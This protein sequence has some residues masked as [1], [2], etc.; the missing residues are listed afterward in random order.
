MKAFSS[1]LLLLVVGGLT[2]LALTFT[3]K[4]LPVPELAD[5]ELPKATPPLGMTLS[6]LPTGV[7]QSQAAFAYRGGKFGDAREFSMAGILVHHP[8]G[9]LLFDTG[10]G[11]SVDEDFRTQP[12]LMQWT[13]KYSKGTPIV[14]QF[15]AN[16]YDPKQL[17]G[18]VLTHAH[19]DH[20]S[21]LR[22]LAG[23]PVWVDQA[24]RDFIAGDAPAAALVRGMKDQQY[25]LYSFDNG[26]YL[27]YERSLDVWGDG[28]VVLVPAPGHTPG[29][30][31]AF[32][33]LP[34][35]TRY[36]LLGD[37]VWQTEGVTLPAERPWLSRELVD[38]DAAQVRDQIEHMA[39]IHT[40]FPQIRLVPAHD[41]RVARELPRY[42]AVA[43]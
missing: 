39:A 35:N 6:A 43:S 37:L 40:R 31:I 22:D 29:S 36:A 16:A 26:P 13:T 7:M 28:S 10:F 18:V 8:K 4:T 38:T 42:P 20:V 2:G 21:G 9:D 12:Q 25:K 33:T 1:L 32:I 3:P 24:E 27:G 34:S 19:W 17:A 30:I 15:T 14:E 11:R 5:R 41:G 23:V